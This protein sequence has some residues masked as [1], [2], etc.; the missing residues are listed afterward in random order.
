[1]TV[2]VERLEEIQAIITE[3]RWDL[4]EPPEALT[5]VLDALDELGEIISLKPPLDDTEAVRAE[6]K[7]YA[8][9][10]IAVGIAETIDCDVWIYED[11]LEMVAADGDFVRRINWK[12][13]NHSAYEPDERASLAAA[14]RKFA[15]EIEHG[16]NDESA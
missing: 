6:L 10:M 2:T 12:D 9:S 4:G 1:M 5:S 8:L 11:G 14:L 7:P 15:D 16:P 3:Q 13:L